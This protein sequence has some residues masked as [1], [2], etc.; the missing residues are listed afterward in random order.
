LRQKLGYDLEN[1]AE[2]PP[3]T[4][5][6]RKLIQFAATVSLLAAAT[7]HVGYAASNLDFTGKYVHKGQKGNSDID[8]EVTL[9]VAQ[10]NGAI[11]I[12]REELGTK[13][14]NRYTLDYSEADCLTPGD[15][16]GKCKARLKGKSLIVEHVVLSDDH[17]SGVPVH[18]RTIEDWQL[19][20]D[21]KTLTIRLYVDM[22]DR[23]SSSGDSK[24]QSQDVEKYT[25]Q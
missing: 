10:K 9:E 21:S 3:V 19:S 20:S 25:R 24:G 6:I 7:L 14:T 18:I 2:T 12:T 15:L 17:T 8:P 4:R 13:T 5:H 11:E 1:E 23:P 22:P 16:A